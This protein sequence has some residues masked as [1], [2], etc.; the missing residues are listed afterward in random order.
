MLRAAAQMIELRKKMDIA[1]RRIG[2][3]PNM[4]EKLHHIG[5]P[6]AVASR[7]AEPV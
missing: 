1:A 2:L 6:A 4:S 7:Y 5:P 3:R